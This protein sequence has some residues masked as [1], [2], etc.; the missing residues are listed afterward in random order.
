[1][2]VG[3]GNGI[4][5]DATRVPVPHRLN[6]FRNFFTRPFLNFWSRYA[7]PA[8]RAIRNVRNA[9]RTDPAVADAAYSYQRGRWLAARTAVRMSGPAKLGIGELSRMA[10]PNSPAAP[11]CRRVVISVGCPRRVRV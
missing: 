10:N 6:S 1:M 9:P 3:V 5:E 7:D 4:A 11:R 8:L 2:L